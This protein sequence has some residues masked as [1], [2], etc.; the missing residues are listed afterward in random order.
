[1]FGSNTNGASAP[2]PNR[3]PAG[4]VAR[5]ESR[6]TQ[7][8]VSGPSS[9]DLYL[10]LDGKPVPTGEVESLSIEIVAPDANGRGGI[11]SAVLSRYQS[12]AGGER[13][14]R[15][16]ALFPGTVEI[17]ARGRRLVV[18]CLAVDS[19]E[20]LWLGLGL[21]TDG[22]NSELSG[23][24]SLRLAL[25]PGLLDARLTWSEDGT[26]EDLLPEE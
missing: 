13:T 25:A 5:L 15:P 14:Q 11:V 20:G 21:R 6:L 12:G 1:M 9:A 26:T 3:P 19:F 22:T 10:F 8:V 2:A 7:V 4:N 18:T 16:F 23:V 17:T 24:G